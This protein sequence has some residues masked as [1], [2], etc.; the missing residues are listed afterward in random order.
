MDYQ[1]MINYI[2]TYPNNFDDMSIFKKLAFYGLHQ[3]IEY[4][5]IVGEAP[6]FTDYVARLKWESWNSV[7]KEKRK[8]H[9]LMLEFVCKAVPYVNE[10]GNVNLYKFCIKRNGRRILKELDET[11]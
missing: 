9:D 6:S 5:D 7:T 3:Q 4:G 8:Y 11:S 1:Y 10:T 2:V